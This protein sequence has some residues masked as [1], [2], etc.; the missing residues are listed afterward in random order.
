MKPESLEIISLWIV[1]MNVKWGEIKIIAL[2]VFTRIFGV[3]Y[4]ERVSGSIFTNKRK[5]L[6]W[7]WK[8]LSL[9]K[10]PTSGGLWCKRTWVWITLFIWISSYSLHPHCT[11]ELG[12]EADVPA[13]LLWLHLGKP[14][15]SY[16][17][18]LT[19][20]WGFLWLV[21]ENCCR[22]L[23]DLV[24]NGCHQQAFLC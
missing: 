8:R 9:T 7:K 12:Q 13:W 19:Y 18:F 17:R 4:I 22:V 23:E 15:C 3:F 10:L 14:H 1:N 2:L 6:W 20:L 11:P 21:S 16:S 24:T 5:I